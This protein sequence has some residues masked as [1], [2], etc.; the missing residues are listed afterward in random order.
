MDGLDSCLAAYRDI[1]LDNG[2]AAIFTDCRMVHELDRLADLWDP[3]A[4]QNVCFLLRETGARE[5][6]LAVARPGAELLPQDYAMWA[7]LR[8]G[9]AP[10]GIVVRDPVGLPAAA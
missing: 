10:D 6:V 3:V 5:V 1:P 7:D 8:E 9:L 4:R 2:D